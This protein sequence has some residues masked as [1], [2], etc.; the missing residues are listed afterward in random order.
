MSRRAFTLIELLVVIAIV[1]VLVGLL[2]PAVQK[3]REAAARLRCQNNLKQ[4]GLG[5][6]GY[7]SAHGRFPPGYRDTR[8]DTA[9]GPGWGWAVFILPFVEQPALHARIDPHT[10]LPGGGS[11][12]PTP[13][14][15][16]LT[17]LPVYRCPS[18]P[19][20]A[21][22]AN[23]DGHATA[24]Y[25]GVGWGRPKTGPGPKGLMITD[26]ADPNGTL[27]RN[28]RVRVADVA[29][30][31]SGTLF[32]TE[33]CLDERRDRW[34]GVWAGATRKDSYGLWIS[35]A[36]WAVDEGPFRLNGPDKWAACSPHPGGVGVLLGDGSARLVRDAA[37]P[38]VPADLATRAGGEPTQVE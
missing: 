13:T 28:S 37:D 1:A 30:G 26:L 19:G 21:T 18:D 31:L 32:V 4:I 5:L 23:Y 6:H 24:S 7:E 2:L 15:D 14:A 20:P 17:A 29:D 34:G 25:R 8:P 38:R 11:D 3:V 33:V 12:T 35:G 27:F 36:F 9:P 22:N 10:T 16:T